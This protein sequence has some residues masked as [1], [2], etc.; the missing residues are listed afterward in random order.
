MILAVH[1]PPVSIDAKH[2]GTTGLATDIDTACQAAGL[3][4]DAVLSGHAHLYQ[5][6]IRSV[7]GR[8]IPYIVAGSGGHNA[9]APKGGLPKPPITSGEYTLWKTFVEFGYSTVTVDMTATPAM[10]S[11]RWTGSAGSGDVVTVDL[12]TNRVASQS[13][14]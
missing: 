3:W 12:A 11:L 1:H 14:T 2:G 7:D 9:T 5:R 6:Y 8:Q 4:P 10:L 13:V